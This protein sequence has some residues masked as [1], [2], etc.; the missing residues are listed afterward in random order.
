VTALI[1]AFGF[2]MIESVL[3]APVALTVMIVAQDAEGIEPV[4][5]DAVPLAMVCV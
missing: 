1:E 3:A 4:P 2:Q 5:R